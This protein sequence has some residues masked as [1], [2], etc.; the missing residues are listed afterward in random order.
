[1]SLIPSPYTLTVRSYTDGAEDDFGNPTR[2]EVERD[3]RVRSIDPGASADPRNPNRD[4]SEIAYSIHADAT[5]DV[6]T[7]RDE[8][9]VDGHWYA[10][11]GRPDDYSRGPWRNP[12]AGVVVLLR[13]TEG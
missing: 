2:V 6:P 12:V 5:P 1:M 7:E 9:R 13:R 3:W 11:D 4:L 8:V 10:V